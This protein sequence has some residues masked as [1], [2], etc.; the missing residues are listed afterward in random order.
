[1]AREGKDEYLNVEIGMAKREMN[2]RNHHSFF[3][4]M[5]GG[6]QFGN[7]LFWISNKRF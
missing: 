4:E 1:M 5:K 6:Q 3:I 7:S 2:L